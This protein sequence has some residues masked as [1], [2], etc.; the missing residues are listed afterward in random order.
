LLT[1][2]FFKTGIKK[3]L[4]SLYLVSP[5][6]HRVTN[7]HFS[8]IRETA[9]SIAT[10]AAVAASLSSGGASLPLSVA[11]GAQSGAVVRFVQSANSKPDAGVDDA[12]SSGDGE[13]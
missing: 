2:Y 10:A 1:N 11:A 9:A 6:S 5:Y 7:T 12:S 8:G 4:F 13:N 3:E